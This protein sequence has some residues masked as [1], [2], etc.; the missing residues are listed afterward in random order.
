MRRQHDD[1]NASVVNKGGKRVYVSMRDVS[2]GREFPRRNNISAD[3]HGGRLTVT[4]QRGL[5]YMG[6]ARENDLPLGCDLLES[7]KMLVHP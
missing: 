1:I 2:N 5:S 3:D 7:G 6:T 4:L